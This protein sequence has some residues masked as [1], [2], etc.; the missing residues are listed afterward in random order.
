MGFHCAY[1]TTTLLVRTNASPG[2]WAVPVPSLAVFQPANVYPVRVN[3]LSA[4]VTPV[5]DSPMVG[6]MAPSPPFGS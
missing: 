1:R 2:W 6:V 4:A 3:A 5:P